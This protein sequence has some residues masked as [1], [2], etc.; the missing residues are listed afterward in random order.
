MRAADCLPGLVRQ[1]GR[2]SH[3]DLGDSGR[4]VAL[5]VGNEAVGADPDGG[6]EMGRIRRAK[7]VPTGKSS[8]QL[9]GRAIDR[10]QVETRKQAG[11]GA[12]F[13]GVAAAK[14]LAQYFWQQ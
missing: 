5:I 11:K 4:E 1:P 2:I 12:Y 14:W 10:T 3:L 6:G 8:R 13:V 7:S 9:G